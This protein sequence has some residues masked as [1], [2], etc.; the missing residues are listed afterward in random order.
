MHTALRFGLRLAADRD[1]RP[2]RAEMWI[3]NIGHTLTRWIERAQGGAGAAVRLLQFSIDAGDP[4]DAEVEWT[5]SLAVHSMRVD[6]ARVTAVLGPPSLRGH[7]AVVARHDPA[8][9]PGLF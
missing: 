4:S 6:R 9:S 1:G 8:H 3:D 2:P 7:A 5:V